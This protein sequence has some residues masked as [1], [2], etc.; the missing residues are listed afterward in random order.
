MSVPRIPAQSSLPL[1]CPESLQRAP[2]P[3]LFPENVPGAGKHNT[4]HD[5]QHTTLQGMFT[6]KQKNFRTDLSPDDVK[7]VNELGRLTPDQLA[8]YIKNV[9]NTAYSLGIDEARQF[10]R[11]KM[12][13]IFKR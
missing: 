6:N 12:L 7:L 8:E 5:I 4:E 1:T 11:G 3:V 2:S 10:S 9:Q 13:Q